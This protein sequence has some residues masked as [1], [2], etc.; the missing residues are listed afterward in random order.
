MISD[1]RMTHSNP[2]WRKPARLAFQGTESLE[3][4]EWSFL[5]LYSQGIFT[6]FTIHG[7]LFSGYTKSNDDPKLYGLPGE[8]FFGLIFPQSCC[9]IGQS[10]AAQ[11]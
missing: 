6:G 1:S 7:S 5:N 9:D 8:F 2:I 11:F 3:W 10:D 4:L